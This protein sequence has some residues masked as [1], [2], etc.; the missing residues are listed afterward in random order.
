MAMK[1]RNDQDVHKGAIEGDRPED[2][3][4]GNRNVPALNAEGLP[5]NATAIAEERIGANIDSDISN[6]DERG[7]TNEES[8]DELKPLD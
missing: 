4:Q 7:C 3:Q 2:E 8:R 6:A 5:E 1:Q